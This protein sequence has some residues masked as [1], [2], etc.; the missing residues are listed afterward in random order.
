MPDEQHSG[1]AIPTCV[2]RRSVRKQV[3]KENI[4]YILSLVSKMVS[5]GERESEMTRKI[6][7]RELSRTVQF[8]WIVGRGMRYC[9][10]LLGLPGY[11]LFISSTSRS[12]RCFQPFPV[13]VLSDYSTIKQEKDTLSDNYHRNISAQSTK[14]F[15]CSIKLKI[16]IELE[17]KFKS[18]RKKK[19]NIKLVNFALI[20]QIPIQSQSQFL[21]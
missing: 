18:I 10:T 12:T 1:A 11:F 4:Q 15:L 17:L 20:G 19:I 14:K 9:P 16:E 8:S 21:I 2:S 13:Q 7:S 5:A 3:E 6:Y